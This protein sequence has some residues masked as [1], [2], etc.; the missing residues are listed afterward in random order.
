MRV[1]RHLKSKNSAGELVCAVARE[2]TYLRE[3]TLPSLI[4]NPG[5]ADVGDFPASDATLFDESFAH[6]ARFGRFLSRD[7]REDYEGGVP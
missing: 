2:D 5:L 3:E 6:R 1:E 4:Q 7:K